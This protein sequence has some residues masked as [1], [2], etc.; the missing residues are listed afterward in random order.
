MSGRTAVIS[1]RKPSTMDCRRAKPSGASRIFHTGRVIWGRWPA[2]CSCYHATSACA[3]SRAAPAHAGEHPC[4]RRNALWRSHA[5]AA[6]SPASQCPYGLCPRHV[7]RGRAS[8]HAVYVRTGSCGTVRAQTARP[9]LS[10]RPS[11]AASGS[12]SYG[13]LRRNRRNFC[14][15]SFSPATSA[16]R[17]IISLLLWKV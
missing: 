14:Y 15:L 16:S 17:S 1:C 2:A 3:L 7:G 12:A 13:V 6:V 11:P 10:A 4:R 9:S 5:S 8:G